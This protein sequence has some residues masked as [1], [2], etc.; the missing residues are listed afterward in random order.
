[1]VLLSTPRAGRN[2][3]FRLGTIIGAALLSVAAATATAVPAVQTRCGW[4]VAPT[5]GNLWLTD[6]EATWVIT[7]QGQA[8]GPDA[9]GTE[10]A[11]SFDRREFVK[12][13]VP[14]TGYGYGCACLVVDI[15]DKTR[16]ITRIH[17]GRMLLLRQCRRDRFLPPPMGG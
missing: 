14:G 1:M 15:D 7:S 16:R 4:Y 2:V 10:H 5:P 9:A 12:T 13:N 3:R 11:P 6:R 8:Q 17:S